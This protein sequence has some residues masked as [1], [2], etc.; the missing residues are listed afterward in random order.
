MVK[1]STR[2]K[3]LLGA[4][5]ERGPHTLS[6]FEVFRNA[7]ADYATGHAWMAKK[8]ETLLRMERAGLVVGIGETQGETIWRPTDAGQ[9]AYLLTEGHS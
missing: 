9:R 8:Y 7:F 6:T 3:R 1:L 5:C 4:L 2:R